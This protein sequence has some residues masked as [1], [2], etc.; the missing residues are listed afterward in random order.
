MY[1]RK[2]LLIFNPAA[3]LG[4]ASRKASA[5][6]Q[7]TSKSEAVKWM[8]TSYPTHATELAKQAAEEG[9]EL[10]IAAGG[11][12]T[13]HEVVNGLMQIG[14]EK[15]PALSVIPLGSGNDFANAIGIDQK[16]PI[17]LNQILTGLR[18]KVD[19][20]KLLDEQGNIYY[21][22]NTVGIGF[23]T[24]VVIRSRRI[25]VIRGFLIYLL[26]VIQTILWDY[27]APKFSF[28]TDQEHWEDD[29]LML[30]LCNGG[31][32]GGIFLIA[33]DAQPGDGVFHYTAVRKIS[34][35][36]MLRLLPE[37]IRGTHVRHPQVRFG[38]FCQLDLSASRSLSIH[39]DGEILSNLG[40]EARMITIE[41]IQKALEVVVPSLPAEL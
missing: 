33:P 9:V 14:P 3:N 36:G 38:Q 12:G 13:I 15:R 23:D 32:E 16:K 4:R 8:Q 39:T 19:I 18:K 31:R 25:P 27:E 28:K 1:F 2:V 20:G 41:I 30:V 22:N 11:D 29:L 37:F 6:R 7:L 24:K 40:P 26:S 10:V 35:L 21:W 5:L 34:R 17:T